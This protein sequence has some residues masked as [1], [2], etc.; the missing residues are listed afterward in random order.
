MFWQHE[1]S[2]MTWHEVQTRLLEVQK[3]H[4]MCIHKRELSQLGKLSYCF[5]QPLSLC[6]LTWQ[7][8]KNLSSKLAT[9]EEW[10]I[11]SKG[12]LLSYTKKSFFELYCS[13][14]Q[15]V[16]SIKINLTFLMYQTYLVRNSW[17]F[18]IWTVIVAGFAVASVLELIFI[19]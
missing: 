8:L 15:Y 2:N 1:L 16:F 7:K 17:L 3:E 19:E 12:E 10:L 4:Q 6:F 11:N 13:C 5:F 9:N 14:L 18:D